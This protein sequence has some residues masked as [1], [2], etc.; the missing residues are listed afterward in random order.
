VGG[1]SRHLRLKLRDKEV[2]WKA[3]GFDLG[4]LAAEVTPEIDVVYNL[5]VDQWNGEETLALNI[6]D[7]APAC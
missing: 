2:I 6:L 5:V 3:I 7:F 1:A 4:H